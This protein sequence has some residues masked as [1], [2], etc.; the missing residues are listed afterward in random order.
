[1]TGFA[2]SDF[3]KDTVGGGAFFGNGGADDITLGGGPNHVHFG[4]FFI[5]DDA[6]P[7]ATPSGIIT[8]TITNADDFAYQGFWGVSNGAAGNPQPIT[9][10]GATSTSEDITVIKGFNLASDVLDF[11]VSAWAGG[12]ASGR[13]W[14]TEGDIDIVDTSNTGAQIIQGNSNSG[15]ESTLQMEKAIVLD[16]IGTFADANQLALSLAS[17]NGDFLFANS[18]PSGGTVHMLVGYIN[19]SGNFTL[20]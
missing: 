15:N 6:V 2:A 1:W 3:L 18:I 17:G 12:V 8:Q 14:L 11:N 20:A 5:D 7:P 19:T 4:E 13:G 16:A 9:N 10:G